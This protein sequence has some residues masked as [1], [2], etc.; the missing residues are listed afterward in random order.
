MLTMAL[1]LGIG[2]VLGI[3][4]TLLW[5]YRVGAPHYRA[6]TTELQTLRAAQRISLAAWQAAQELQPHK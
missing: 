3:V 2:L 5:S 1:T 6:L 4:L